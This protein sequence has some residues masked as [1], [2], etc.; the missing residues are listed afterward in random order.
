MSGP[1]AGV[2]V[3]DFT[4][5]VMGPYASQMLGDLG[6]DVVKVEALE[7]D[8][9]RHVGPKRNAGM[10]PNFLH[11]NRSKRSIALD[12]KQPR[13]LDVMRRLLAGADVFLYSLRPQTVARLGLSYAQVSAF[14]PS[15]IHAGCFGYGQRGPRAARPAYDDLIQGACALPSL[16]QRATGAEPR[17][18]PLNLADRS[19][20]LYAALAINAALFERAKSGLGQELHIPM[21]ETLTQF[22]LGDHM[23]GYTHVPPTAGT[24][25]VRLVSPERR[26]FRTLDGHVCVL[27]YSDRQ[28]RSFLALIGEPGRFTDDPRFCDADARTRHVDEVQGFVAAHM[29]TRTTDE[30]IAALE[31]ADIPVTRMN[32]LEDLLDDPHHAATGFFEDVDHPSEG[33]L[34]MMRVPAE[35]GRT[36]AVP[37]RLAPRLGEHGAAV[38]R[39]LGYDQT[40]IDALFADGVAGAPPA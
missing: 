36:P 21:F 37:A 39:E 28:W 9:M 14:N 32:S 19:V 35:F 26:P 15:I 18:P 27:I 13:G 7:G 3:V 33:R 6:A 31:R 40:E 10:G 4:T 8:A 1:L 17:Y 12:L 2:K 34:R 5:I 24:G 11:L 22:V 16:S 30:W 38:L 29:A 23:W 20:G 25:Y